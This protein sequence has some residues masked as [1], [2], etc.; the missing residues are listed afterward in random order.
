[1][2]SCFECWLLDMDTSLVSL[3]DYLPSAYLEA[4]PEGL[5]DL[6]RARQV[7]PRIDPALERA[8]LTIRRRLQAH[9]TPATRYCLI[10]APAIL[11]ELKALDFRPL[12]CARTTERVLER[13]GLTA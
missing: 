3:M 4:G 9:A 8:I 13:N 5:Y 1:M 12:P 10:G 7:A 6:T 2:F 11:A